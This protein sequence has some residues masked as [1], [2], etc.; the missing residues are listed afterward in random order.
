MSMANARVQVG[1]TVQFKGFTTYQSAAH[2]SQRRFCIV[3]ETETRPNLEANYYFMPHVRVQPSVGTQSAP[4]P[5]TP[6]A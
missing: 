6:V 5:S 2:S 3:G 1:A 4:R